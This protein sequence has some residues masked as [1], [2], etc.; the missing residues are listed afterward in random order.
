MRCK[1]KKSLEKILEKT[2]IVPKV[3]LL[4]FIFLTNKTEA[5]VALEQYVYWSNY[6]P[7]AVES[8]GLHLRPG[9]D[10]VWTGTNSFGRW[11]AGSPFFPRRPNP[12]DTVDIVARKLGVN[13]AQT[14]WIFPDTTTDQVLHPL[15]VPG[16]TTKG[17][18]WLRTNVLLPPDS[19]I[20]WFARNPGNKYKI[21]LPPSLF[22]N[23]MI[24]FNCAP[25]GVPLNGDTIMQYYIRW[26][27]DTVFTADTFTI[28]NNFW[29][30]AMKGHGAFN[31]RDSVVFPK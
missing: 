9:N 26:R 15:F 10:T 5:S 25:L 27:N 12:G 31:C 29:G 21:D 20:I 11:G 7:F 30:D 13:V 22:G 8:I 28:W 24:F 1:T 6:N 18:G 4:P 3:M 16:D 19:A 17:I 2:K 14:R 23:N